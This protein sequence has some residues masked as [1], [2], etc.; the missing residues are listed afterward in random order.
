MFLARAKKTGFRKIKLRRLVF[1]KLYVPLS[2]VYSLDVMYTNRSVN[3]TRN[4]TKQYL[5]VNTND[6]FKDSINSLTV[7]FIMNRS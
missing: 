4:E 7:K 5:Y 6:E 3:T 1:P 2:N